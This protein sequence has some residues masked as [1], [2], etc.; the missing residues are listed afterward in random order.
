VELTLDTKIAEQQ[1]RTNLDAAAQAMRAAMR[2]TAADAAEAIKTRGTAD[3][4][5]A[6]NF[7]ANW[8]DA[9]Q[10]EIT[11]DP[12]MILITTSMEGGPPVSYWRVFEHGASIF[13]HNPTGLLTWPNKSGFSVGGKEPLFISKP[14]VTIQ[15][16]FHLHD[17]I[18]QVA[19]ELKAYYAESMKN[20]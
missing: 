2:A 13:A 20:G 15:Q 8:Q 6:G 3:I 4:A 18:A 1:L 9:L 7:G 16:K 19:Q 14:S 17:I 5:A 11:E 12:D 10:V